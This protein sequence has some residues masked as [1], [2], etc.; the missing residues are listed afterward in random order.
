[1]PPKNMQP[2]VQARPFR[3][4]LHQ[5]PRFPVVE[6]LNSGPAFWLVPWDYQSKCG[7]GAWVHQR[8][9]VAWG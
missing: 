5:C 3:F 2:E 6:P 8:D 7:L 9:A 4:P 1:M